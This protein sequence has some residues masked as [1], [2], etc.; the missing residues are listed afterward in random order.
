MSPGILNDLKEPESEQTGRTLADQFAEFRT[1]CAD[2]GY[3]L[4]IGERR[5]REYR[6]LM[7]AL[8]E[9]SSGRR[10]SRDEMNAR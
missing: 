1:I 7:D 9:A 4:H 8:A 10:F 2:A 5:N 3:E 6:R